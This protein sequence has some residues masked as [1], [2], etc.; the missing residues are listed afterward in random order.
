MAGQHG[1]QLISCSAE[2]DQVAIV[3]RTLSAVADKYRTPWGDKLSAGDA[4]VLFI[5]IRPGR[6]GTACRPSPL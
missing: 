1:W 3:G 2:N 4:E 5:F 6:G